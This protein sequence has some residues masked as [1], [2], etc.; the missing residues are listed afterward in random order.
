MDYQNGNAYD[1]IIK[2]LLF[3]LV[4]KDDCGEPQDSMG[5]FQW[6]NY[7]AFGFDVFLECSSLACVGMR[8]IGSQEKLQ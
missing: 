3:L 1:S 7:V 2:W 4:S 5:F 6:W 8:N